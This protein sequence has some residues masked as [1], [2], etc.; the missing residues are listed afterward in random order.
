VLE[1]VSGEQAAQRGVRQR[2]QVR[3]R[4]GEH[5]LVA[6]LARGADHP[7]V[8]VDAARRHVVLTQ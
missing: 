6:G 8:D 1:E 4:V 2:P 5:D 7:V 3:H